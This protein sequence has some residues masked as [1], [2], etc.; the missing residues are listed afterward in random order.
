MLDVLEDHEREYWEETDMDVTND[1]QDHLIYANN[2]PFGDILKEKSTTDTRLY[3]INLNGFTL[4]KDGGTWHQVMETMSNIQADI[5]GFSELNK[6]VTQHQINKNMRDIAG[7]HFHCN[8]LRLAST[9]TQTAK[10]YKPGGTAILTI[11]STCSRARE[12]G[13]DRMGRWAYQKYAIKE[14]KR[15]LV[16]S[17]YQVGSDD[18]KGTTTARSQQAGI[19][20][21]ESLCEDRAKRIPLLSPRKA[22][23]RDLM[24]FLKENRD[25]ELLLIGD[26][27]EVLGEEQTGM[28]KI[29]RELGLTDLMDHHH[30]VSNAPNSWIRGKNR[31]DF[32]LGSK[33]VAKSL[34][35]CGY[36][37]FHFRIRSDHR[38]MFMDFDTKKLFGSQAPVMPKLPHRGVN[39]SDPRS[40]RTFVKEK[41]QYLRSHNILQRLRELNET[42]VP[43]HDLA[44]KIDRDNVRASKH[45][46]KKCNRQGDSAWSPVFAKAHG[47]VYLFKTA[48]TKHRTKTDMSQVIQEI[49]RRYGLTDNVP[50]T[51]IAINQCLRQA[52]RHLREVRKKA[53][54]LRKEFLEEKAAAY[55][56]LE[57]TA[58]A[59]VLRNMRKAEANRKMWS[60]LKYIRSEGKDFGIGSL[61][62]PVEPDEEPR[63][64]T[65]WRTVETPNEI[66]DLLLARN[67]KHFGQAEGTPLT[68]SMQTRL[69]YTGEG[70]E[71]E[72][73]LQGDFALED[74]FDE[75]T[76]TVIRHLKAA[77]E[78]DCIDEQITK[79]QFISKL[80]HWPEKTSTSPSGLHLGHYHALFRPSGIDP[81]S[82]PIGHAA[83]A[84]DADLIVDLHLALINYAIRF[85][86]SFDRWKE[87]V[88][89]MLKKDPTDSR[90]HRLRVIHLYEADYN[91]ILGI[92]WREALHLAEDKHL[93]N[94][95]LYG[96]RAGRSAYEP[97]FLE[98]MQNEIYRV[99][100]KTGIAK[101][102]DAQACYDRIL[103][104]LAS[105][106][107]R[108]FGMHEKVAIVNARTLQE[109][110]FK[111]K[112]ALGIS[113]Q[114]YKHTTAYPIHGT[115]QGSQN[116]PTIWLFICSTLFDAFEEDAHG[117]LFESF[118]K[119]LSIRIFMVGFV[120]DCSQRVNDFSAFPQPTA[121]QL[122]EMMTHD[123]QRWSNLL[124]V[125]GGI[126]E[127]SKG[128]FHLNEPAA[129]STGKTILQG[130]K[131]APPLILT[132]GSNGKE[133]RIKQLS[134][135]ESHK[136]LGFHV[137]PAGT[138]K[139][140]LAVSIEKSK[141]MARL[142]DRS[143]L[144]HQDA[145]TYYF[146]V[147]NPSIGYILP[148]S[149]FTKKECE[150]IQ[151]PFI[152]SIV[153]KCGFRRSTSLAIRWGPSKMGGY[154]FRHAYQEKG[155]GQLLMFM[156]HLR[157][158]G[159]PAVI[160]QIAISWVQAE[161]GVSWSIFE[162]TSIA[163][164]YS[165]AFWMMNLREFL[166]AVGLHLKLTDTMV[167]PTQRV[168]DQH[169]MDVVLQQQSDPSKQ[170]AINACRRYLQA[171]TLA[172]IATAD[173]TY[174]REDMLEGTFQGTPTNTRTHLF[175]QPK[176][177]PASWALWRQA[178]LPFYTTS[179][180]LTQPLGEWTV[181]RRSLRRKWS[182][183]EYRSSGISQEADVTPSIEL[184]GRI[185]QLDEW[186]QELL[187]HLQTD[188]SPIQLIE[189]LKSNVAVFAGDGSVQANAASF[190]WILSNKQGERIAR[191][192]G[193]APGLR[194]DSFRA[195]GYAFISILLFLYLIMDMTDDAVTKRIEIHTD[196]KSFLQ[197]IAKHRRQKY[198]NPNDTLEPDWDVS[199]ETW[200]LIHDLPVELHGHWVEGH[201]DRDTPYEELDLPA[202]L[203][204][205]AD[206]LAGTYLELFPA[207]RPHVT[208]LL[209]NRVQLFNAHGTI[210]GKFKP[211]VREAYGGPP[212]R[213]YMLGRFDW[214]EATLE[215]IDWQ[216]LSVTIS[217]QHSRRN[218]VLKHLFRHA[219][220]GHIANQNQ[221]HL[222]ADCPSCACER[223]NNDH[224]LQ[225]P[226]ATRVKW[227]SDMISSIATVIGH[228]KKKT[229][230]T[231]ADI[232]RDGI[233]RWLRSEEHLP[234]DQ[235][236]AIYHPLIASQNQIGWNQIFR[237][238]YSLQWSTMQHRYLKHNGWSTQQRNGRTWTSSVSKH[239]LNQWLVLWDLRN[240]ERHGKDDSTR[241]AVLQERVHKELHTLYSLRMRVLPRDRKHFF[242]SVAEHLQEQPNL[243]NMENWIN[244]FKMGLIASANEANRL[245][246]QFQNS[247]DGWL[248]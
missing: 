246:I 31:I 229:D 239:F 21:E 216:C 4:G 183:E 84:A 28:V 113:S 209:G 213:K 231:L 18:T 204:V 100:G 70:R 155:L 104:L 131:D 152:S 130:R 166:E 22:F 69:N 106:S 146:A 196:S 215:E 13:I 112:T 66:E 223:E 52:Q 30:G 125:S 132:A 17:C 157:S 117:A 72:L 212:L 92:K 172:D 179:R 197:R 77:T 53:D 36:D 137:N 55:A 123:A 141:Q 247:L 65:E 51:E 243:T 149:M 83:H 165:A 193:P 50:D 8:R 245:R 56:L 23:R 74:D 67:R 140:Q 135:Y 163:L 205:D 211:R 194:P 44:E 145:W 237:G 126:L 99:S 224:V 111:L 12:H 35:K 68:A 206:R 170:S 71:A 49:K 180:Q 39:A 76:A 210:T 220:T 110:R 61:E 173:G 150:K 116:S 151:N 219:P 20:L 62:V 159:Q 208:P 198:E 115:G 7:K 160:L 187:Q 127:P 109:A 225:C 161:C 19:I 154:G 43:L 86:F 25:D 105:L 227:R 33:H 122:V 120:D 93:L 174:I 85:S 142:V 114:H 96:S 200:T 2:K 97:V 89:V 29:Q 26:F 3:F 168:G 190:G 248:Q 230:P 186:Q 192:Y 195:E 82:D 191:C 79:E 171:T 1:E 102:L 101:D 184:L 32:A 63:T 108:K 156:K 75:Y 233:Q 138:T 87:V 199:S 11:N 177:P 40:V 158:N 182:E 178:L 244:T 143:F 144:D 176:P 14:N 47:R 59:T 185:S 37:P 45:A 167:P 153:S 148:L 5:A 222:P 164:K 228:A 34:M 10:E 238:R 128:S 81:E 214:E 90:I 181:E 218:T 16:V 107:S 80:K 188:L 226:A 242:A 103:A 203:N 88:N 201:Q 169:I 78:L 129:M 64:C 162:Q 27:N 48:L 98:I 15:L 139:K 240:G 41:A 73:I 58:P 118:D 207:P 124:F 235:Y 57:A 133:I 91:M 147:Y 202:Q 46:E 95:G 42:A 221:P 119:K 94:A 24:K 38:G 60:K 189:W 232:L 9:P 241:K 6:D 217:S 121:L 175:N 236:P 234:P 134:A 136:T 54:E